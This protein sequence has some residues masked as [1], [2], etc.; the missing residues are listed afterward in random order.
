VVVSSP[1]AYDAIEARI[2]PEAWKPVTNSLAAPAGG[3]YRVEVR[4]VK[5]GKPVD[6][7]AVEHVGVGEV[8]VI[9]GQSNSTNYGEE[10]QRTRTR[11][12]GAFSGA[13][14]RLADGPQPGVQDNS[15]M[16]SFLPAF[17]DAL[18]ERLQ[19]PIGVA[20]V[21]AGSTSVCKPRPW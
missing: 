13:G 3:W 10:L 15:R 6:S 16:G 19:V 5:Q 17:G 1:E 12:V 4:I 9:A 21:G 7:T 14:W 20:A 2:G 8:F 11:M 18:Y